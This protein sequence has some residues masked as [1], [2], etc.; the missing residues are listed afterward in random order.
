MKLETLR[1]SGKSVQGGVQGE[2]IVE[3]DGG[4]AE[5][6]SESSELQQ[7]PAG[8]H[9]ATEYESAWFHEPSPRTSAGSG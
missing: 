7:G 1:A 8:V 5:E 2:G 6:L 9:A 3:S 4:E